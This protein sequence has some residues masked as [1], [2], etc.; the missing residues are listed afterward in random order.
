[1]SQKNGYAVIKVNG[2]IKEIKM[3]FEDYL[4][5]FHNKK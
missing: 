1:M 5:I 2:K 3:S 4:K